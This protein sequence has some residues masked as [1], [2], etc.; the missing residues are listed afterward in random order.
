M[1]ISGTMVAVDKFFGKMASFEIK[2]LGV[3]RVFGSSRFGVKKM[4][5]VLDLPTYCT[6]NIE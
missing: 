3:V 2:Y 6:K 1:L 4:G 5:Y